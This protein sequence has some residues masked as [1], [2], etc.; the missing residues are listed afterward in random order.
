MEKVNFSIISVVVVQT[1]AISA[2]PTEIPDMSGAMW[3]EFAFRMGNAH[4]PYEFDGPLYGKDLKPISGIKLPP[5][6]HINFPIYIPI[7]G[8]G[9]E[10]YQRK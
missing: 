6:S 8:R 9:G 5:S 3:G 10:V 1:N 4:R 2:A 7:F